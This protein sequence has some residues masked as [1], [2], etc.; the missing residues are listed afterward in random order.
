[1]NESKQVPAIQT[2]AELL[3]VLKSNDFTVPEITLL[4]RLT[5]GVFVVFEYS[6]PA[7]LIK[8]IE[9]HIATKSKAPI[10][11]LTGKP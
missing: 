10:M 11:W 9:N 1:M 4:L 5:M 6:C 3:E 7:N 8:D 2:P